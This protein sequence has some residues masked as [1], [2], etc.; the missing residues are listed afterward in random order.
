VP[1]LVAFYDIRPGDGVDLQK[2]NDSTSHVK[3]WRCCRFSSELNS[4]CIKNHILTLVAKTP[5]NVILHIVNV[6]E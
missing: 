2:S 1:G 5:S 6:T 4:N 3:D